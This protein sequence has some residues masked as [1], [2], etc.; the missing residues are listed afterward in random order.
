[1][2]KSRYLSVTHSIRK[3]RQSRSNQARPGHFIETERA[4][5]ARFSE[6]AATLREGEK[7]ALLQSLKASLEKERR[8]SFGRKENYDP[9]R[10]IGLYLA[11]KAL[12][13]DPKPP[14]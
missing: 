9:G 11:V 6:L 3:G 12:S 4:V 10:H 2:D 7:L 8:R 1:M 13:H 5:A 14:A